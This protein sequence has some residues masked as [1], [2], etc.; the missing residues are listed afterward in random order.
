MSSIH[1]V[2]ALQ[3]KFGF[4]RRE[5]PGFLPDDFMKMRLDFALEELME[6]AEACGFVFLSSYTP[7]FDSIRYGF[8]RSDSKLQDLEKAL[9]ALVDK[10]YVD[11]GT[12]DLMGFSSPVPVDAESKWFTI[13]WTAWDR[14]HQANMKKEKGKTSRGHEIDLKKPFGWIKPEFKDLLP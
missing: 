11:L 12:A 1:D 13:W 2:K 4:P 9:D 6:L 8:H 10:V 14:V 7:E 3:E 5:T